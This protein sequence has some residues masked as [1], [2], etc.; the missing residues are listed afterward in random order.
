MSHPILEALANHYGPQ[1]PAR[2]RAFPQGF[3]WG[4]AS[5]AIQIE[6][7]AGEGNRGWTVWDTFARQPGKILDGTTPDVTCDHYHRVREDVAL[8]ASLG[9]QA[10]RFSI[11]WS[12]IMPFGTGAVNEDGLRFYDELID[13]LLKHN[14]QPAITLYHWDLPQ[15]LQDLGGW[16]NREIVDWFTE[17][18]KVCFARFGDRVSRWITLNEPYVFVYFGHRFGWMAP[19]IRSIPIT[20]RVIHHALLAHGRAVQAFRESGI[21]GEIGITNANSSYEPADASP[22]T[23]AAVERARDFDSRLFHGPV[24]GKG[25]PEAV[26]RY[27]SDRGGALPVEPGDL[28]VIAAQTDFLG[29]NLYSRQLV[30]ADLSGGGQGFRR[31]PSTLPLLDMGYEASP[32]ALG[33]FVRW[34]TVE[35]GRRPIYITENGVGEA[36]GP[37]PDGAID[38]ELRVELLRGFLKGLHGAIT[39]GC[40]VRAYYHWSLMDNW[41]WAFG[42]TKRFGLVWTDFDTLRRTPKRSAAF[43]ADAALRNGFDA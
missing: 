23:A 1:E 24:F 40:D 4:V 9:V 42:F 7:A 41:E 22:E 34:V 17:Y 5:A 35:Y 39:D 15:A 26:L 36:T 16:A 20:G 32:H 28:D 13:E 12:R 27:F 31:A 8:M 43:F 30:A 33:D 3:Q 11:A 38:D 29:V 21:Q 19:G 37:G 2:F 14:I 10:Y 25:Y 18:A 6:G